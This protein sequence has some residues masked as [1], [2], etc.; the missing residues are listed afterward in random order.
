[1]QMERPKIELYQV[2]SFGEKFSAT[3]DFLRENFRLWLRACTYLILPC[4]A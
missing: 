2:R 4:R 1:M 3:F